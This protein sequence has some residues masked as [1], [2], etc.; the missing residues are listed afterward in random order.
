[1]TSQMT[2]A[3]VAGLIDGEGCIGIL[4][5]KNIYTPRVDVGMTTKARAILEMLQRAYGGSISMQRK[6]TA[7]WD[8]A[9]CWVLQGEAAA[10]FLRKV[11]PRLI[12]KQEQ[13]QIA[14]KVQEIHD[15]L[16]QT[17]PGRAR[18]TD[19]ARSRC[20][21]LK[22]RMHELNQKGP[23][24]R[25]RETRSPF[26]RL[27][28]GTWVTD[29]ADMFSDLGWASFKGPWPKSGTWDL[30]AAYGRPT[31]AP[32]TAGSGSSSSPGLPTPMAADGWLSRGKLG[33]GGAGGFGLRDAVRD[34]L[35]TPVGDNA[36]NAS[37]NCRSLSP[38]FKHGVTL[39][40]AV[41]LLKTPTA[42]LAVNGGSQHPDKRRAGG[43]GPTLADQVECEL[44]PTP[45][46]RDW[47]SGQSNLIGTN[48]RPLNEVV[49]MLLPTP[50][51]QSGGGSGGVDSRVRPN[52]RN[53]ATEIMEMLP[54]PPGEATSPPSAA[55]KPPPVAPH[56]RQLSLGELDSD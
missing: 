48:A 32:R 49:E 9:E 16:H 17:S 53:L 24:T 13:C 4:H 52:G 26:A 40:D 19:E 11:G 8:A 15:G 1:M 36:R 41:A 21:V 31:S 33:G 18:W 10:A 39:T 46:A 34:L 56:P 55:G 3:Y 7:R 44:L 20:A 25:S 35:P 42:Q 2:D 51:V 23:T 28:A 29:Q 43:H 45:A 12:L 27:V 30:G 5:H 6:A 14:L 54:P 38:G 50:R 47:K 22:R 37:I